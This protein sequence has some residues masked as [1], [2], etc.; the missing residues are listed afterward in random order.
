MKTK[1]PAEFFYYP[2]MD[3][4]HGRGAKVDGQFAGMPMGEYIS[5][6]LPG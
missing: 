3:S 5:D 6:P 1:I 4:G 2:D